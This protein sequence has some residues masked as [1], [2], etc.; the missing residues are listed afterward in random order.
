MTCF[1]EFMLIA[2]GYPAFNTTCTDKYYFSIGVKTTK[3]F[4]ANF[5]KEIGPKYFIQ[6][7]VDCQIYKIL[8]AA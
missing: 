5:L 7:S 1:M 4:F 2:E 3:D 6:R 8:L